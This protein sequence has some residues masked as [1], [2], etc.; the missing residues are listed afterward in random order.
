M[1]VVPPC[2][3]PRDLHGLSTIGVRGQNSLD[4]LYE[5]RSDLEGTS[6]AMDIHFLD[7]CCAM[8]PNGIEDSDNA[9]DIGIWSKGSINRK[10]LK[11]L[12][13]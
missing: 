7:I 10:F 11:S 1:P 5:C 2:L 9:V 8:V 13:N 4:Y 6:W 12:S 3:P